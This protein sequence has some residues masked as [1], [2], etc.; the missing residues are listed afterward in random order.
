MQR[1]P[2]KAHISAI[3]ADSELSEFNPGTGFAS[4]RKRDNCNRKRQGPGNSQM[5]THTLEVITGAVL[6][7]IRSRFLPCVASQP[8]GPR[9]A[10]PRV[11][12]LRRVTGGLATVWTTIPLDFR[13]QHIFDERFESPMLSPPRARKSTDRGD[14]SWRRATVGTSEAFA[15]TYTFHCQTDVEKPSATMNRASRKLDG[16]PPPGIY[17]DPQPRIDSEHREIRTLANARSEDHSQPADQVASFFDFVSALPDK[18][19]RGRESALNCLRQGMGDAGAKS[20][21]LVA[22]CRCRAIPARLVTAPSWR[23][24]ASPTST[25]GRGSSAITGWRC[26]LRVDTSVLDISHEFPRPP[27][28]GSRRGHDV[29]AK[30]TR[31]GSRRP[32]ARLDPGQRSRLRRH[33]PRPARRPRPA[34]GASSC[35]YPWPLIVSSIAR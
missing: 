29:E 20:R 3:S 1:R 21:L 23:R 16:P 26:A 34:P 27:G 22:L 6:T 10:D 25:T 31:R 32:P 7:G 30:C 4:R 14:L 2:R 9:A 18:R 12:R 8:A 15:L 11:V 17:V 35:C 28:D 19:P 5:R 33:L 24:N 13:H